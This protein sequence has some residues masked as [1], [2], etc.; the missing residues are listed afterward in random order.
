MAFAKLGFEVLPAASLLLE[1]R[2]KSPKIQNF[3]K[4]FSW[5]FRKFRLLTGQPCTKQYR[6]LG[7]GLGLHIYIYIHT[8]GRFILS[9]E[10]I[11]WFLICEDHPRSIR[12]LS[13]CIFLFYKSQ[14]QMLLLLFFSLVFH[15]L[16][17]LVGKTSIDDVFLIYIPF[18]SLFFIICFLFYFFMIC[19][20]IGQD[21]HKWCFLYNCL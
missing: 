18:F 12:S 20:H 8:L 14:L 21:V 5:K 7:L 9:S 2:N 4:I 13:N 17:M 16:R 19:G 6:I 3:V 1:T 11:S 15:H 10:D